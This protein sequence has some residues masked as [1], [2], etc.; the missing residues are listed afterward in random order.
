VHAYIVDLLTDKAVESP[1]ANLIEFVRER[2]FSIPKEPLERFEHLRN[3]A[4]DI[5]YWRGYWQISCPFKLELQAQ[6][7]YEGAAI[8]AKKIHEQPEVFFCLAEELPTY[9]PVLRKTCRRIVA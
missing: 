2:H 5:L 7:Y 8:V 1:P 3:L 6:N 4:D 9:A